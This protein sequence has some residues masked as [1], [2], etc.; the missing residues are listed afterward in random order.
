M[1]RDGSG[2]NFPL[3]EDSRRGDSTTGCPRQRLCDHRR[4]REQFGEGVLV[5]KQNREN[6]NESPIAIAV[7]SLFAL[8][9][10]NPKPFT[11][12]LMQPLQTKKPTTWNRS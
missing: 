9:F 6:K 12:M 10:S 4:W 2:S 1:G 5:E 7:D 11:E 8:G 3:A